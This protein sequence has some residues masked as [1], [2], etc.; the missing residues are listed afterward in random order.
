MRL[1]P[2][3]LTLLTMSP[4]LLSCGAD[5]DVGDGVQE[6]ATSQDSASTEESSVTP[7]AAQAPDDVVSGARIEAV[8]ETAGGQK[9]RVDFQVREPRPGTEAYTSP[10]GEALQA[11]CSHPNLEYEIDDPGSQVVAITWTA[12]DETPDGFSWDPL[13]AGITL[14]MNGHAF[15]A[16]ESVDGT[17]GAD[18]CFRRAYL[19]PLETGDGVAFPWWRNVYTPNDPDPFFANELTVAVV[20]Q[21]SKCKVTLSPGA[22]DG[23]VSVVEAP[24]RACGISTAPDTL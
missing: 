19:T 14:N 2:I 10:A 23:T 13:A 1:R 21:V 22:F 8:L 20:N 11:G 9:L 18:Y 5:P 3:V 7:P 17:I 6:S 16:G 12:V 24:P 15:V 4:V